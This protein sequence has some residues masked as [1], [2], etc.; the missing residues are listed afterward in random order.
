MIFA[1]AYAAARYRVFADPPF[2]LR[3]GEHSA[4]LD[5]LLAAHAADTWAFVTACNPGS[6]L[7]SAVENAARMEQLREVFTG[8]VTFPAESSD[9]AGDWAEPSVLVIG[10]SETEAVEVAKAFGQNA[11]LTGERGG[12]VE[13]VWL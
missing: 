10:I 7:L 11:I 1:A 13:L 5:A 9:P 2:T 8:F 4:E 12:L 6:V 3:V